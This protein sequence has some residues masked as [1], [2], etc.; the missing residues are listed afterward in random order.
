MCGGDPG[1]ER[2]PG[3]G[4]ERVH[5]QVQLVQLPAFQEGPAERAGAVLQQRALTDSLSLAT[6]S[7]ASPGR[8]SL[9]QVASVSV[10]DATYFGSE[11]ILSANSPIRPGHA[12]AKQLRGVRDV[13]VVL[14]QR[15]GAPETLGDHPVE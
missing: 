13:L 4:D 7:T 2:L 9:F 11:L 6:A 1:Q 15:L 3:P 14:E 12:A 10:R 8:I 5:P